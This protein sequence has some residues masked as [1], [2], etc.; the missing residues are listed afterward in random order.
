MILLLMRH[1][2]AEDACAG[3]DADDAARKLTGKGR[4]ETKQVA[5]ALKKLGIRPNVFLS[6]RRVRARQTARIVAKVFGV[7]N[8]TEIDALDCNSTFELFVGELNRRMKKRK[9]TF[10]LAAS[11]EPFCSEF[12]HRAG[13]GQGTQIAAFRKSA[14][15]MIAWSAEAKAGAGELLLYLTPAAK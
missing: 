11:H 4:R 1:G 9:E 13:A 15:A 7:K 12:L 5:K 8:V 10:V 14:V 3:T 2:I 6:S